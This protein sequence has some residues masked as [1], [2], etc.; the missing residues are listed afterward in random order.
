MSKHP[1]F[2]A[3]LHELMLEEPEPS[4][5]ALT[6]WQ[7]RYPKYRVALA[8]Y[9]AD[10]AIDRELPPPGPD[11]EIDEDSLVKKGVDY[12]MDLLRRQEGF[13]PKTSVEKL[14]P[15][16]QLILAAVWALRGSGG[17]SE[18]VEKVRE[19]SGKKVVLGTT[20]GTL[21]RLERK[22][23]VE[24]RQDNDKPYFVVTMAGERAL[25]YAR[26]TSPAV[27]GFLGGLA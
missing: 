3:I 9:F 22:G 2:E 4:H 13:I 11:A 18:I 20:V 12:A 24:S 19:I 17:I 7:K 27:D 21:S 6:R 16:S 15:F 23:L 5:E 26:A 25:A 1:S 8:E 14:S 10:W